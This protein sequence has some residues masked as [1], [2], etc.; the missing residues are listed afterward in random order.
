MNKIYLIFILLICGCST[1]D[2]IFVLPDP[3]ATMIF[4]VEADENGYYHVDL[5]WNQEFY[6]YFNVD[7]IADKV[8]NGITSARFDTDT[9]WVLGD[10]IAF[11]IPLY[12]PYNGLQDYQGTPIPVRDTIVYLS[13]FAGT[14]LPVVQNNTRIYFSDHDNGYSSRRT[15]GPFPPELVGDTITLY[16][17]VLWEGYN[18]TIEKNNYIEKFIVE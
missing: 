17:K 11:T 8:P 1:D 15:V 4:P 6:P 18:Y 5:D 2:D 10:S 3:N 13:Q 16:M 14:I 9:Y 7:V 12:S